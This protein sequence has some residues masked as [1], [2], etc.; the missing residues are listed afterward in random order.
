M[1]IDL[2]RERARRYLAEGGG[3]CRRGSWEG[4]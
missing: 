2:Y 4:A 1:T 3:S